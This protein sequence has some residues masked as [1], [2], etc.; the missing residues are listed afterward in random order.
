MRS[1]L[2]AEMAAAFTPDELKEVQ[3]ELKEVW[4]PDSL[5]LLKRQ[6]VGDMVASAYRVR[7]GDL[8]LIITFG[9]DKN[10]KVALFADSPDQEYQ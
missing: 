2:S 3:S 7:K 9:L 5:V 1:Q 10:G 8:A 6:T 4:P